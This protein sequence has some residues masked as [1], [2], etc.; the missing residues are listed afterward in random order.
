MNLSEKLLRVRAVVLDVDGI[1]TDGRI[2]YGGDGK[3]IK[4]FDVKD[5]LGIKLLQKN[6]FLVGILSG[7]GSMA[8]RTRAEELKLDFV[9]EK[10]RDKATAFA[11][12]LE[13][14]GLKASECLYMGD[15]LVDLAVLRQAGVSATV[16][17][18]HP[19]VRE[20]C[21]LVTAARGGRGAVREVAELLLDG[22]GVW[23]E[24]V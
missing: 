21:L 12:L 1:L 10:K 17:D 20:S 6:G 9:Y 24:I 22:R 23:R 5:G 18:A 8:N 15:D 7:R 2:G 16:S 11:T 4:F 13:E 14:H 19:A 3:E